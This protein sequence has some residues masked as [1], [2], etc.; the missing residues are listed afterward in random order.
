MMPAHAHL[1][2]PEH[3]FCRR[4]HLHLD[5]LHHFRIADGDLQARL[6]LLLRAAGQWLLH[7]ARQAL[8]PCIACRQLHQGTDPHA[9]STTHADID[10]AGGGTVIRSVVS[11]QHQ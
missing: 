5:I 3:C 7:G 10:Q 9:C 1:E 8:R 4:R 11:A 6:R 2:L